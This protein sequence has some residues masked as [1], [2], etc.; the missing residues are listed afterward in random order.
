[1]T[2]G[3]AHA[4]PSR[5]CRGRIAS[6]AG[7]R[8]P[9]G[10]AAPS[11]VNQIAAR[12]APPDC[13]ARARRD[14]AR[15]DRRQWDAVASTPGVR[16]IGG[17]SLLADVGHEVPTALLPSLLTTTLGA[18]AAALGLIEGVSDGLAGAARFGGGAL[19]D[20]PHRRRATAVGGY[21]GTAVLSALIGVATAP[22]RSACCAPAHGPR[23]VCAYR[24]LANLVPAAA[25]G[26]ASLSARWTTSARSADRFFALGLVE[27]VGVRTAILLSIIPACSPSPQSSTRS[28]PPPP[29]RHAST[30]RSASTSGPCSTAGSADCLA[31]IGVFGLRQRHSHP[32]DPSCHRRAEPGRGT[33]DAARSRYVLYNIAAAAT[34]VPAGRVGDR[35]GMLRVLAGGVAAFAIR[36][37][38]ITAPT[39]ASRAGDELH[40]GRNRSRLRRNRRTRSRRNP[41]PRPTTRLSIRP[42][43]RHPEPRQHNRLRPR[44]PALHDRLPRS[45]VCRLRGSRHGRRAAR[46]SRGTRTTR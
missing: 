25:Y 6:Y 9:P 13:R 35:A 17:A 39:R 46:P 3:S 7:S 10:R 41:R 42:P 2:L 16:G 45:R 29:R 19:A 4:C 36:I 40:P 20:D 5:R 21:T 26:R 18:P 27:L 33:D 8:G 31:G 43:G 23:A 15:T 34:S 37:C 24:L 14:R 1:M 28:A 22:G 11:G 12:S 32:A 38:Q 30:A 44:R